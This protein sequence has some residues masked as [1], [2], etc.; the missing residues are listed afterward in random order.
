VQARH[1]ARGSIRQQTSS[2]LSLRAGRKIG[3]TL[4]IAGEARLGPR[5][6]RVKPIVGTVFP[7][8]PLLRPTSRTLL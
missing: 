8:F 3:P 2:S 6:N 4:E 1:A 5:L 7:N